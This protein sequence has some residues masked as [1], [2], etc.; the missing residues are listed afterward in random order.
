MK[1]IVSSGALHKL[2][3]QLNGVISN[4]PVVPI[5]ENFLL[6]LSPGQLTV[7]ASDL[8]TTIVATMPI[9]GKETATVAVPARLLLD[10]LKNLPSQPLTVTIDENT[11]LVS[12]KSVNGNFKLA[13][14]NGQDFPRMPVAKGAPTLTL[15]SSSLG[16]AI[17]KTV[18]AV[19]SDELRPAM[20]GILVELQPE[21][22]VFVA[23]DGHRL[24]RYGRLDAGVGRPQDGA[25][26]P[27]CKV[28]LPRKACQLLKGCLPSESAPVDVLLSSGNAFFR[29]NDLKLV[30]RLIDE[31][32]PDYENVIPLSN[33]N[34]LVVS[35]AEL[36]S[37]LKRVSI[38]ANKTTHQ[39]R[40]KMEHA[41]LVVSAEDLDF[42]NEAH[43]TLSCQYEGEPCEVG[44]NVKFLVEMLNNLDCEEISLAMS[45]PNRAGLLT[46]LPADKA[47][48]VL[49]LVMPVMLNNYV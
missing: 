46:P 2:L 36:L 3:L 40:L 34:I 32:Y 29:F 28:I 42:S 18:F 14:E 7:Q 49:M 4:N 27:V 22:T 44:Y 13:G 24:L 8:E 10:T 12:L 1:F 26:Q 9:E 41:Q 43:E 48:D 16:R 39:V 6:Q 11:N 31:R 23:T 21:R 38:Y 15:P 30:C 17:H 45:T 25:G 47:E 35:R 19:S 20:T 5:L 37:C 33:P